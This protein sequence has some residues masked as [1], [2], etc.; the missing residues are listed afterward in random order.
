M[1]SICDKT[2][3]LHTTVMGYKNISKRLS[4]KVTKV[5]VINLK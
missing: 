5:D 1:L 3:E 2:V 4:E